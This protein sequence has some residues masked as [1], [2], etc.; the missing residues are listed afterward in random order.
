MIL[1]KGS[2]EANEAV[3]QFSLLISHMIIFWKPSFAR[4]IPQASFSLHLLVRF[5]SRT[6][7]IPSLQTRTMNSTPKL[8]EKFAPARRVAGQK[9]DVW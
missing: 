8:E 9:Q 1:V 5:R 2:V 6:S 3:G 7:R 4:V